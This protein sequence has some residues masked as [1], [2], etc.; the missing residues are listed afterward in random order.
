MTRQV[1]VAVTQMPCSA[2]RKTNIDRAA[3]LVATAAAQGAQ[4]V[5]L[6]ELFQTPYFC[7]E[8][9]SR[10]KAE[11]MPIVENPA[12]AMMQELARKYDVVIPVSV[13]ERDGTQRFN[14]LVVIDAGESSSVSIG[15]ATFRIFQPM[16]KLSILIRATLDSKSGTQNLSNWEPQSVGTNGS[17]S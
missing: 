9:N 14:S 13:Y 12:I 8:R 16:R 11:A 7:I 4:V 2:D 15:K 5:V 6:Q 3:N 10:H 1:S 17:R